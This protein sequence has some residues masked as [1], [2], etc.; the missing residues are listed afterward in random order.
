MLVKKYLLKISDKGGRN[1]LGDYIRHLS[2]ANGSLKELETHLMIVGRLGY[3]K[4]Q[5]LKVTLNKCEEIGRM[6]HS[7]IEKLSQNKKG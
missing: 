2:M 5:E 3:L 6:L 7:L 4:E 1:H